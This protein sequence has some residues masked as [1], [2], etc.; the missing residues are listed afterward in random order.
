M[1]LPTAVGDLS[2]IVIDGDRGRYFFSA[3]PAKEV[4]PIFQRLQL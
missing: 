3:Y 1:D 2:Q 4:V